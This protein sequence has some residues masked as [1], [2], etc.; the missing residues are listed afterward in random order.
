M[1][2][3]PQ[4]LKILQALWEIGRPAT[5]EEV[6]QVLMREDSQRDYRT[7]GTLLS[8]L[9]RSGAVT[10]ELRRDPYR[11]ESPDPRPRKGRM[12]RFYRAVLSEKEAAE[13]AFNTVI[14]LVVRNSPELCNLLVSCAEKRQGEL[15]ET[16]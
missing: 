12:K 2:Y 6:Q 11:G 10:S 14:E 3:A 5:V 9:E 1:I 13:E 7:V 15:G 4:S 16:P 8:K